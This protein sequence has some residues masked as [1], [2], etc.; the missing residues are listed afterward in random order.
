MIKLGMQKRDD[1]ACKL[2]AKAQEMFT[3]SSAKPT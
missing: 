1:N 2:M 3:I